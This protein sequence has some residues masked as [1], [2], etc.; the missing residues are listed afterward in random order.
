[1]MDGPGV[2]LF[3]GSAV[4]KLNLTNTEEDEA[5]A[6]EEDKRKNAQVCGL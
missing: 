1:M 4:L 5:E 6:F 3:Q 2:S